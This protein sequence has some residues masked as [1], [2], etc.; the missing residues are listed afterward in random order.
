MTERFNAGAD[1]TIYGA[2]GIGPAETPTSLTALGVGQGSGQSA[3]AQER[4][5]MIGFEFPIRW[6]DISENLG[7][8]SEKKRLEQVVDDMTIRDREL[9]DFLNTNIVNGIV[10]GSNITIDRASGVVTITAGSPAWTSWTPTIL[11]AIPS[12]VTIVS[13]ASRYTQMGKT[14]HAFLKCLVTLSASDIVTGFKAPINN[15]ATGL[16]FDAAN[17]TFLNAC[18]S[19]STQSGVVSMADNAATTGRFLFRYNTAPSGT[20]WELSATVTYEAA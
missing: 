18:L 3:N 17:G 14:V 4:N 10:A 6:D 5:S 11:T 12:T 19:V 16:G 13:N 20:T 1:Q 2:S 9:E 15:Y 7:L 8:L